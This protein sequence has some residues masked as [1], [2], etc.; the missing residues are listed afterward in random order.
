MLLQPYLYSWF[1]CCR[2]RRKCRARSNSHNTHWMLD[3]LLH[4]GLC[5]RRLVQRPCLIS[6]HSLPSLSFSSPPCRPRL[7]P[8][9]MI[10]PYPQ[11][12]LLLR[13]FKHLA[14]A[15]SAPPRPKSP[16]P[17]NSTS[18]SKSPPSPD[19]HSTPIPSSTK[20]EDAEPTA[21]QQRKSDWAIIKQL[22]E[23]VWPRGDGKTRG[24]V[25]FSFVLLVGSKVC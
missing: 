23:N 1:G 21:A 6:S 5:A 11:T 25:L 17:L 19:A 10:K 2:R 18:P 14:P 8:T 13:Q 4:V 3:P 7:I 9:G 16:P 22:L 20:S 24:I 15:D 12:W